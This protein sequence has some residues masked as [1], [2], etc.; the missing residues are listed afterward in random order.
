MNWSSKLVL[1]SHN[2]YAHL[3][4]V[5]K[6]NRIWMIYDGFDDFVV[7]GPKAPGAHGTLHFLIFFENYFMVWDLSRSVPEAFRTP[8]NPLI[9][10]FHF[11]FNS[12]CHFSKSQFFI[13]LP[14]VLP[15]ELPINRFGGRYCQTKCTFSKTVLPLRCPSKRFVKKNTFPQKVLPRRCLSKRLCQT[16]KAFFPKNSFAAKVPI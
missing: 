6:Q 15:I 16:K 1:L 8:G 11:I 12:E 13:Q 2:F 10:L 14:I 3:F 7:C 4:H 9:N 5:V